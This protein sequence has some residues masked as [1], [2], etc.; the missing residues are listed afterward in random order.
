MGSVG[1]TM[2]ELDLFEWFGLARFPA[3]TQSTLVFT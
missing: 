1:E 2:G 3:R